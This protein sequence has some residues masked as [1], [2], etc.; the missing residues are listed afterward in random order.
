[1]TWIIVEW[2]N[3]KEQVHRM[4]WIYYWAQNQVRCQWAHAINCAKL[5]TVLSAQLL[6]TQQGSDLPSWI[7]SSSWISRCVETSSEQ[8]WLSGGQEGKLSGLFCVVLCATIVHSELHTHMN[9]LTVLWI[10]FCLF[11][12]ISLC[13]DS[14]LCMLLFCVWLYIACMCTV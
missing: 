1:M 2:A 10:G 3:Q 4:A 7:S 9:R 5:S 8:W 11:G 12:P 6:W 14:F 13:L